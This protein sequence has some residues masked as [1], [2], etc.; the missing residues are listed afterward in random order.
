MLF[1]SG[2]DSCF[3]WIQRARYARALYDNLDSDQKLALRVN[4]YVEEYKPDGW[5]G[6]LIKEKRVRIAVKKALDEFGIK[7]ENRINVVLELV[8]N[9]NEY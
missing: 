6:N 2:I 1:R 4:Q 5:R 8:K 9:Q 7:D 3:N